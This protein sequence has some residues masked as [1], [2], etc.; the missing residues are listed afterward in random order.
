VTVRRI[1][2][3]TL[4]LGLVLHGLGHAVIP[5]RGGGSGPDP[6]INLLQFFL[7]ATALLGF[8]AAGLGMLGA[9]PFRRGVGPTASIAALASLVVLCIEPASDLWPGAILS[10][11]AGI[12][13]FG[14]MRSPETW[15]HTLCARV[16]NAA[17]ILM[18]AYVS[19]S[20]LT[21]PWH[22]TWGVTANEQATPLAGDRER[23]T[24]DLEVMHAVTIAAP[25]EAVWPW[26]VQL[27]Q[28]RGG[29]YSYD[30]LERLFLVDIHNADK[31]EPAWQA[32]TVG[33]FVRATQ[34]GYLGGV[35]GN[36]LGWYVTEVRPQQA[37][38]LHHWG[39]F[40]L[41]PD[42]YG[43]TR[44]IVRSTMSHPR[45]P[46]WAAAVTFT[47]FELPHFIMERRMLLGI[48]E[49]AERGQD[50]VSLHGGEL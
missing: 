28:D 47:A 32:R 13:A 18:F 48:K 15:P 40:V 31:L 50:L 14:G 45:V 39:A 24:R 34:P 6:T 41:R 7:Y 30:W 20:T 1:G 11:A 43:G 12:Y 2:R 49:R 9:H 4:G 37:L 29:F 8:V 42:G 22:R 25:P 16:G 33:D 23:R 38:V 27:G 44:L 26:L 21:F 35:L 5:L 17:A 19:A 10:A 36:D 46:V 3:G